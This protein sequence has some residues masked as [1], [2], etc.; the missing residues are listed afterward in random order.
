MTLDNY[1]GMNALKFGNFTGN[2]KDLCS[3]VLSGGIWSFVIM[4]THI[5]DTMYK[6]VRTLIK[7]SP[8]NQ[9]VRKN[10]Q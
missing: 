4:H 8:E 7:V 1:Y 6:V 3:F 10:K 2:A 5:S 9:N